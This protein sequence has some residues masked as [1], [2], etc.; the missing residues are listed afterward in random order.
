MIKLDEKVWDILINKQIT[1]LWTSVSA[2]WYILYDYYTEEHKENT[3]LPA[4]KTG[5]HEVKINRA[6][7]IPLS[8]LN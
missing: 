5:F 3:D 7:C 2:L 4:G 8:T 6:S 1:T